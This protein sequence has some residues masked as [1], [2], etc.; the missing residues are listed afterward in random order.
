MRSYARLPWFALASI[1][2]MAAILIPISLDS[3]APA[4][5]LSDGSQLTAPKFQQP[6]GLRDRLI[7][8][9]KAMSK[10][11]LAYVDRVVAK[12]DAGHLPQRLVDETF[13][14]ARKR[15]AVSPT[16]VGVKERRPI[17]YFRPVLTA[18]AKRIGVEL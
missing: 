2:L 6:I 17:I 3:S 9:L 14:W 1:I 15:V 12:V 10:S 18:Q 13:V 7:V 4:Q 5:T 11:D 16:V 8:G